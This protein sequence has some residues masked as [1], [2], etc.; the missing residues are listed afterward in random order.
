MQLVSYQNQDDSKPIGWDAKGE[1]A[2]INYRIHTD[3]VREFMITPTLSPQEMAYTYASEAD[4]IRDWKIKR[5][6]GEH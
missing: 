4:S 6:T 1:L 2:K 5:L 3:A